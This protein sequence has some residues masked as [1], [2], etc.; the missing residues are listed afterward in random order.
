MTERAVFELTEKGVTLIEIAPG[1]DLEKDILAQMD[2]V[3][4]I[5]EIKQ[6]DARLFH[7]EKMGLKL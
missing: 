5:G 2:F 4:V 7:K 6:M 3:P 1:V